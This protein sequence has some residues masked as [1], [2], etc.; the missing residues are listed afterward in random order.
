MTPS[1]RI[2][3]YSWLAAIA[4]TTIGACKE[5][6]SPVCSTSYSAVSSATSSSSAGGG[7]AAGATATST[8]TTSAGGAAGAGGMA[9]PTQPP[10]TPCVADHAFRAAGAAFVFPTPPKLARALSEASLDGGSRHPITVVLR[11]ADPDKAK[12][13]ASASIPNATFEEIFLGTPEMTSATIKSGRF[14]SASPQALGKLRIH[15]DTTDIDLEIV[16]LTVEVNTAN[17]C[18]QA[19]ISLGGAINASQRSKSLTVAGA[20]ATVDELAGGDAS[21]NINFATLFLAESVNFDFTT[22]P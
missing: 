10:D 13:V 22:L 8:T 14:L 12:L 19:V 16:N 18:G 6:D 11:G 1:S 5:S 4:A 21:A 15:D 17:G 2:F 20:T 7:G 9:D 3:F